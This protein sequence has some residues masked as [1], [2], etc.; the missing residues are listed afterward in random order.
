VPAKAVGG[1]YYDF[2]ELG[3]HQVGLCLGDVSG[4][5]M[6][7]ALLMA[8]L[9]ATLRG[10]A[11]Q[12]LS[13]SESL[14]RSNILLLRSTD[15][16]RF[17][18]LF[19]GILDW[20]KHSL[21]YCNA[22]HN[23]PYLVRPD[24]GSM[25]L[26]AGGT[27]LGCFDHIAYV[28]DRVSISAGDVLV[29]YSDGITEAT[30]SSDEGFGEARLLNALIEGLGDTAEQLIDRIIGSVGLHVGDLS[31]MDDMTVVVVKRQE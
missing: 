9:Q 5:G 27:V 4:K 3:D 23:Y 6:P 8:N 17:A 21:L 14:A 28:D 13:P 12:N 30:N 25:C 22:G 2:I 18:T 19:F 24:K 10:Q 29:V 15:S 16:D 26:D 20:R 1:D 7:A 31:Q 11:L